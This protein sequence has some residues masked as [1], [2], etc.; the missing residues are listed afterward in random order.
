MAYRGLVARLNK[1]PIGTEAVGRIDA[2]FAIEREI[3]GAMP[4]F[5]SSIRG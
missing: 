3:N 5:A 1:V 2:L 4:S